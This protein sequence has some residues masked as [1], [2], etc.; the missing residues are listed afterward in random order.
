MSEA[1][2]SSYIHGTAPS[3]QERLAGLNRLT[4][5]PFIEF[6]KLRGYERAL[7]VGS[8]LGILAADV[9][10][11]LPNGEIVGLEYSSDQIA[12]AAT[13]AR[14]NVRFVQGDAHSLP[15]E[16]EQFDLVY[17]RYVLEHVADPLSVLREMR[18]VLKSGGRAAVQENNILINEFWPPCPTFDR[19]WRKFAELQ[20]ALGGDAL[21]GKRLYGLLGEAGFQHIELSIQPEVHWH[22]S[23]GFRRWV[24][25]LIGNVESGREALIKRGLASEAEVEE[26]IHEAERLM[27]HPHGTAIFYWNRAAGVNP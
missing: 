26:S 18:R 15:L 4:N 11:L 20:S 17:C 5:R 6:L 27:A 3:E 7:E 22:G 2:Q 13:N 25:N 8:G 19:I 24:I 16:D 21:I 14:P 9:G 23:P 1:S 12:A 10:E